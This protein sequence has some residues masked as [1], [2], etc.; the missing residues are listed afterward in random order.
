MSRSKD[1]TLGKN[2]QIALT[3]SGGGYRASVFHIGVLSYLYHLKLDDGTRML[4]HVTVMSTVSGGTITGVNYLLALKKG[5]ALNEHLAEL[6]DRIKSNNLADSLLE[7]IDKNKKNTTLSTIKELGNVYDEVFF[8]GENQSF[9]DIQDIVQNTSVHHFSAYATDIT[10]AMPFR[11]Q[12]VKDCYDKAVV[13]NGYWK[14]KKE[15][16]GR[17]RIADIVAASSCFPMVFEPINYPRD[18]FEYDEME[19]RAQTNMQIQLMDGGIIDNQGVDYL[20][21][22]NNQMVDGGDENEK[23]IDFAIISD[24]AASAE[25]MPMTPSESLWQQILRIGKDIL[26]YISLWFIVVKILSLGKNASINGTQYLAFALVILFGVFGWFCRDA[27]LFLVVLASQSFSFLVFTILIALGKHYAPSALKKSNQFRIPKGLVWR[28]SFLQY[29][30][31]LKKRYDSF[32]KVVST[33]MMGHIR[34]RNLRMILE[35]TRWTNKVIVPCISTLSSNGDWKQDETACKL[36]AKASQLMGYSDRASN[37][38]STLWFSK[39]DIEQRIPEKILVCG[40][41][42]ICYELYL[43][44][45]THKGKQHNI[46]KV[47]G[48]LKSDSMRDVLKEDWEKFKKTPDWMV[49]LNII[50]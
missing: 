26:Y 8:G 38:H 31:Q 18:F 49:D 3:L 44:S 4:D 36:M 32:S 22:A 20:Y 48:Q 17:M 30:R 6:F 12:A 5:D 21:E 19:E 50:Q 45:L 16:A 11:F 23:G 29:Q 14:I 7:R 41:F 35:N 15:K 25:E 40:Q 24:A 10:N 42:S 43:W 46:T 47:H 13:G 1:C 39:T 2:L 37:F 33:V 28:I 34:R 9:S 27:S